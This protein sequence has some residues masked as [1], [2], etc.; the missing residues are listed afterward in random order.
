[1]AILQLLI[2]CAFLFFAVRAVSR[3]HSLGR[4]DY[5]QGLSRFPQPKM[6]RL[7]QQLRP[8]AP[9]DAQPEHVIRA[10]AEEVF[11]PPPPPPPSER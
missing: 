5:P 3:L 1:M 2:L 9:L 11:G 4:S 8:S 7:R 6:P 10:R